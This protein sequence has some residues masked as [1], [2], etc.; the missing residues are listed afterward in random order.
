MTTS[1]ARSS[2]HRLVSACEMDEAELDEYRNVRL[3]SEEEADA[4][5]RWVD[6]RTRRPVLSKLVMELTPVAMTIMRLR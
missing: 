4:F 1:A 2:L 5:F 3:H 6:F